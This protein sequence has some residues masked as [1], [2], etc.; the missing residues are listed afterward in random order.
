[1]AILEFFYQMEMPSWST[2]LL[3]ATGLFLLKLIATAIYNVWFH[4]LAGFP[5]PK[6]AVIGPWYEFYYDVIKDG[7]YL[8][9]IEKMHEKY[10]E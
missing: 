4:P 7:R 6:I 3:G 2:L 1:M 8:W 5:G 9:Q 10:G